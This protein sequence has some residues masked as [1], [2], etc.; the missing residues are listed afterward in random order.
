MRSLA[1]LLDDRGKKRAL[2]A[3]HVEVS[4]A[5]RQRPE[6]LNITI[7]PFGPGPHSLSDVFS[8]IG[9]TGLR[10]FDV[11]Q[12]PPNIVARITVNTLSRID[13]HI[14]DKAVQGIR[15]RLVTL[16]NAPAP[17]INPNTAPLGVEEDDDDYEPDFSQAEDTE[18]ILNKLDGAST[19]L[20]VPGDIGAELDLGSFS[21]PQP[22]QMTQGAALAAGNGV[23]LRLLDMMKAVDEPT[24]KKQKVGFS[25]LAASSGNRDSWVTMLTRVATR[26]PCPLQLAEDEGGESASECLESKIRDMLYAYVMEDFR[27]HIDIAVSWLNEEWYNDRV[28]RK[29]GV[30]GPSHYEGCVLRLIDGFLPYLHAQDKVLTRFLSEIPEL[31]ENILARVK[32]MCRDP[33]VIQLALT[34]LLYL[35]MMRPPIKEMALDAVQDIWL[36]RKLLNRGLASRFNI[37]GLTLSP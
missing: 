23:I 33:S 5:K 34:S 36:D 2:E 29:A 9:N 22:Q 32:Y 30:L 7:P 15:D 37:E 8:F 14:L 25:R 31:N 4:E 26:S 6:P 18:Q 19:S 20:V 1:E 17:E 3:P 16:A 13:Q 27:K 12:V 21:L 35:V 24:G 11:S 28:R 10:N